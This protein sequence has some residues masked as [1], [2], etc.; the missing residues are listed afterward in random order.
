[1]TGIEE[2]EGA[3]A[4]VVEAT[5]AGEELPERLYFNVHTGLLVLRDTSHED[6]DGKKVPD[7]LYYD[8]YREVDGIKVAFS[9]RIVQGNITVMTKQT[10]VKNNFAMDD[11]IF[12][13]PASK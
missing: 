5:P 9:L 12:N 2:V 8:D 3:K 1:V 10:E 13:L 4:Y 11:L 6:S 7:M